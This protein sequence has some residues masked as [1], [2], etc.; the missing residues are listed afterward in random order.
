MELPLATLM[1][2]SP[3]QNNQYISLD[4]LYIAAYTWLKL[5]EH[6]LVATVWPFSAAAHTEEGGIDTNER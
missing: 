5:K 1:S 2:C 6:D 4:S 3:R